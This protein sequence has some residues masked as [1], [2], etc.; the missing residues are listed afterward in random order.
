MTAAAFKKL[1]LKM[2]EA[3]EGAHHGVVDFRVGNK[4]FATLAYVKDGYGVLML[5][6]E[7]Q[8]GWSPTIPTCSLRFRMPGGA[9][10]RR[11]S[12]LLP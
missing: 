4:I 3:T 1:A 9:K 6:P 7:Q 10:A 8:G 2:P 12:T 5:D 11:A